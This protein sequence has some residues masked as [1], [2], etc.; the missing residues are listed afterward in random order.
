[1]VL[2]LSE[3]QAREAAEAANRAKSEF[4]ANMSHELR[5]P[6]N[7]VL[8]FTRL[9]ERREL[10]TDVKKDLEIIL[11]SGE[12]L[13]SLLNQVLDLSKLEAGHAVR[14]DACFD[15]HQQ[16]DNLQGMF[17][18]KAKEK[19]IEF[20]SERRTLP[21]YIRADM[22]KLRQVLINLLSNAIK[23]TSHGSVM[24]NVETRSGATDPSGDRLVFTVTDT[25]PGMR[26]DEMTKLFTPFTQT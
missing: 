8:G 4:L 21:R 9:L 13:N 16:L 7:V 24:L 14:N 1:F 15:L 25:G 20:L 5:S 17:G 18:F 10:S 12:H 11:K 26:T 22:M 23:F 2:D 6:L 3:R 19:G